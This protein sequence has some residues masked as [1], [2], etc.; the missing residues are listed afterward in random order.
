[1]RKMIGAGELWPPTSIGIM[2]M[3]VRGD[4]SIPYVQNLAKAP[5]SVSLAEPTFAESNIASGTP[6]RH[7]NTS[8][9]LDTVVQGREVQVHESEDA[10]R[11]DRV[12]KDVEVSI[13][14]GQC[15]AL[16]LTSQ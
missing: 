16:R 9:T 4:L 15:R 12:A 1:M 13:R 11:P 5:G 10:P 6:L 7:R 2:N 3:A 14:K 8:R